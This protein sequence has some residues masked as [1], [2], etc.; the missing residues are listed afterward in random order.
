MYSKKRVI[1]YSI[2]VLLITVSYILWNIGGANR[3]NVEKLYKAT[4]IE[5]INIKGEIL[6]LNKIE[7]QEL[8][9]AM[10][11]LPL[12]KDVGKIKTPFTN[13]MN[14]YINAKRIYR[15]NFGMPSIFDT[16]AQVVIKGKPYIINKSFYDKLEQL[17]DNYNFHLDTL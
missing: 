5:I 1:T 8:V 14:F 13:N 10:G 9:D 12:S 2:V 16:N 7:T 15:L 17:K 6:T 11:S 3:S 4:T